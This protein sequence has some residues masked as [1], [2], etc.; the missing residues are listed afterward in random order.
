M[1]HVAVVLNISNNLTAGLSSQ[2]NEKILSMQMLHVA[3][4]LRILN[5]VTTGLSSQQNEEIL[6][7]CK[8]CILQLLDSPLN[9]M[10][11]FQACRCCMLLQY[12]TL[13]IPA[14]LPP[15]S[16]RGGANLPCHCIGT[17]S[18]LTKKCE[19]NIPST[20]NLEHILFLHRP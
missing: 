17:M 9:K 13:N 16:Y 15:Y 11:K 20:S 14:Y 8:C 19:A 5:N 2:E 18:A 10:K 3:V 6:E 7:A 1:L 4:V 12:L